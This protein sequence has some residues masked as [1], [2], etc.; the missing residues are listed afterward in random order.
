MDNK[1]FYRYGKHHNLKTCSILRDDEFHIC[2]T[3]KTAPEYVKRMY[4][5]YY[6]GVII[7]S[8]GYKAKC[9]MSGK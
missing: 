8:M 9:I 3:V 2:D 5:N 6:P 1:K 7:A 4:R